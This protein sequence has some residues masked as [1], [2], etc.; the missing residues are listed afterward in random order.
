MPGN[1]GGANWGSAAV[2]PTNGRLYVVS[3]DFPTMLKLE[4]QAASTRLWSARWRSRADSSTQPT[5]SP[6][7]VR[8]AEANRPAFR[9]WSIWLPL[10]TKNKWKR[11]SKQAAD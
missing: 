6:A 5:A 4:P 10:W 3:K 1:K 2:N 8:S 7:T 11:L 9:R